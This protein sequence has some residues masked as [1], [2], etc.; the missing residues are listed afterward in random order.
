MSLFDNP[1][2][3]LGAATK[4]SRQRLE[5]LGEAKGAAGR[6][7]VRALLDARRRLAAELAWF[8]GMT[9]E[10][11]AGFMAALEGGSGEGAADPAALPNAIARINGLCHSILRLAGNGETD[12]LAAAIDRIATIFANLDEACLRN[13]LNTDRCT[14]AFPLLEDGAEALALWQC[15]LEQV[16]IEAIAALPPEERQGI[17]SLLAKRQDRKNP[18]IAALIGGSAAPAG[19]ETPPPVAKKKKDDHL[20]LILGTTLGG[21]F[22]IALLYIAFLVVF[23]FTAGPQYESGPA[24]EDVASAPQ[25][26]P[27]GDEGPLSRG[28]GLP[29]NGYSWNFKGQPLLAPLEITT[30]KGDDYYYVLLVDAAT[31]E[32]AA[33]YFIWPDA[34]EEVSAPLGEYYV[35]FAYGGEWHGGTLL[36]GDDTYYEEAEGLFEFYEDGEYYIGTYLDLTAGPPGLTL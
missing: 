10:E 1:F 17:L 23:A 9:A 28:E 35:L 12:A 34:S 4:D 30:P 27:H 24:W 22:F 7:A 26:G 21:V 8:P 36:F 29:D 18:L 15:Q 31:W 6:E 32:H 25:E 2:Y 16:L 3:F 20:A 5:A 33:A 11:A 19:S 13:I 14:A